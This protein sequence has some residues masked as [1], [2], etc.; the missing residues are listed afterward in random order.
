MNNLPGVLVSYGVRFHT[1]DIA[2]DVGFV[3]PFLDSGNDGFLMGIP[4]VSLSY[5]WN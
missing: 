2:G 3:K 1:N 4:F 5:R